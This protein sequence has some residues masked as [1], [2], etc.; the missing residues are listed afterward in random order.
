[1]AGAWLHA[2]RRFDLLVPGRLS[3][4]REPPRGAPG[5]RRAADSGS[6]SAHPGRGGLTAGNPRRRPFSH[7]DIDRARVRHRYPDDYPARRCRARRGVPHPH[8]RVPPVASDHPRGP[9][10][11]GR[12]PLAGCPALADDSATGASSSSRGTTRH[13]HQE[14]P[15]RRRRTTTRSGGGATADVHS[16]SRSTTSPRCPLRGAHHKHRGACE[17]VGAGA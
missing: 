10:R 1:M 4:T 2:A 8:D 14:E 7:H 13:R 15:M 16:D 17:P 9:A 6:G 11:V 5:H 3:C 12:R